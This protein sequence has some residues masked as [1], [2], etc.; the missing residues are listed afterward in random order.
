MSSSLP[1]EGGSGQPEY[2]QQGD[3]A[4]PAPAQARGSRR[5]A[6][7]AG[8]AVAVAAVVGGGVW[9][10][11]SFL[12]TGPQPAEALPASTIGYA[13]IDLDPS[14]SQKIEAVKMLR[15]FPAFR[16]RI[17]LS[18]TDD[19]RQKIFEE[20]QK[21]SP[22]EGLDY[23]RDVEPWLG[24]RAAIA[25]VDLGADSPAPVVVVQVKDDAEAEAGLGK[26]RDCASGSDARTGWVVDGDWAVVAETQDVAQQVADATA[27][28]S[29]ADDSDFQHWTGEAG[30]PGIMTMY[31]APSAGRYLTDAF[32]MVGTTS[33]FATSCT[34]A[35]G[36][37]SSSPSC[38]SSTTTPSA[39]PEPSQVSDALSKFKGMA[40]TLR[41]HD[42]ALE[43]ELAG[44][45]GVTQSRLVDS[46]HGADTISTLPADTA[47]A[48][49]ASLRDGWFSDVVDQLA[50][51]SGGDTT[52]ADLLDQL[53]QES[54]LD[55]PADAETLSGD[56]LAL[57]VGSDFDPEALVN[58]SDA[59]GVPVALKVTGDASAIQDVLA[60]LQGNMAGTT[61]DALG[62]D[63]EGD[64][65]AIGPDA[66]YRKQVLAEGS[67]GSSDAFTSVVPDASKAGMVMFVNFDAGDD[68]LVKLAGQD[69]Q[70]ADNLA[71]LKALGMS[72]WVD[73]STSH[74]LLRL[75]TD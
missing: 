41:F 63:V 74:A 2:L 8:A 31:A 40:A 37:T 70:V 18:T 13:S 73:G 43:L 3:G 67:L 75:S 61:A 55:L 20:I 71:P 23:A 25:A 11:T 36:T 64:H 28:A 47:A 21:S 66:D 59:S 56:S 15:Q 72:A 50:S 57:A 29:L 33:G 17:N 27:K 53:S 42:G 30:D 26:I 34:L 22:C 1:P 38:E 65:V 6:V 24:D 44:D 60:K 19:I 62:S 58:S 45:P 54:G 39:S 35:P 5:T 16:D 9:A 10:L 68:W 69:Q 52:A 7:I 12:G 4:P 32:G 48:L 51:Y 14:G 49:G 46:E